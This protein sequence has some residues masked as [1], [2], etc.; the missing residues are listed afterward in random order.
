[1]TSLL[2]KNGRLID[3]ANNTDG[4]KDLL[5]KDG[6]IEAVEKPGSIE[7]GDSEIIDAK[8]FGFCRG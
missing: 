8:A 5:V 4:D 3:P 1:M 6:L 2:I 7:A